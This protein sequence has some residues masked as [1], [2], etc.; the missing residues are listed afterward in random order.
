MAHIS[1]SETGNCERLLRN[2]LNSVKQCQRRFG[3]CSEIA[4][5]SDQEVA[6]LCQCFEAV[7]SHGLK[8]IN[9]EEK[10][11]LLKRQVSKIVIGLSDTDKSQNHS[12]IP[13]WYFIKEVLKEPELQRFNLLA[14]IRNDF[15]RGKA[16]LRASIN[17]RCLEKYM[18]LCI[19]NHL[20]INKYYKEWAFMRN[21]EKNSILPNTAAGLSSIVFA[22]NIDKTEFNKDMTESSFNEPIIDGDGD[23]L[24]KNNNSGHSKKIKAN[25]INFDQNGDDIQPADEVKSDEDVIFA[26]GDETTPTSSF[27]NMT[28]YFIGEF[29]D[30][31]S[32]E[33]E[34][35]KRFRKL[36]PINESNEIYE[37]FVP[38]TSL[39]L[40][41]DTDD[42]SKS[43]GSNDDTNSLYRAEEEKTQILMLEKQLKEKIAD[44][45]TKITELVREN[46]L[47]K[48]QLRKYVSAVQ[49]MKQDE[50]ES[51]EVK[52]YQQKLIQ[53]AEMHS[54]LIELNSHLNDQMIAKDNCITKLRTEL[55]ALRGPL[56]SDEIPHTNIHLWVPSAFLVGRINDPHHVYQIHIRILNEEWNVYRRYSQF[57]EFHKQLKKQ[58]SVV[59]T[60]DL[61]PKKT[62]GNKGA[63]F[64]EE[65][66]KRLQ[67]YL[68]QII[69]FLITINR[70]LASSPNKYKLVSLIPFFSEQYNQSY[71][72]KRSWL[73][74]GCFMPQ[75]SVVD[76]NNSSQPQYTGL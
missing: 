29:K 25:V 54:E 13:F 68:R 39:S 53:V 74:L 67:I 71:N 23:L 9:T 22:L 8:P 26:A 52:L 3:S 66:R 21:C 14:N 33:K 31:A 76:L 44:L 61:P 42:E 64:V 56:P 55:V 41:C 24:L 28:G 69:N 37:V 51:E 58:Y 19:N 57:T 59:S 48:H 17:E 72:G 7:L 36:S 63:N 60:I 12:S 18:H 62:I 65:R 16:W 10:S 47:L 73:N 40:P 15:G 46:D 4:T 11:S 35:E 34:L 5:E 45:E 50:N 2:L 32:T 70:T 49:L 6:N 30:L 75:N 1:T 43:L 38:V 27:N 20:L